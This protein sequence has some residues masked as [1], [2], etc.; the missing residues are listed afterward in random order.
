MYDRFFHLDIY[1]HKRTDCLSFPPWLSS[2]FHFFSAS[3]T[4][5]EDFLTFIAF[6][7]FYIL[8]VVP[9][10]SSR[11]FFGEDEEL[12]NPKFLKNSLLLCKF[13]SLSSKLLLGI[14]ERFRLLIL[15]VKNK[16]E[17]VSV[18]I[19]TVATDFNLSY[20]AIVAPWYAVSRYSNVYSGLY[21]GAAL[22]TAYRGTALVEPRYAV[23]YYTDDLNT[24]FSSFVYFL[25]QIYMATR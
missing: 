21:D 17:R 2:A 6:S 12:I 15:L 24:T 4:S 3:A 19:R 25:V 10:S 8:L 9:S 22:A 7:I 5:L 13:V 20:S 16:L 11:L 14:A 23:D 18:E 1:R